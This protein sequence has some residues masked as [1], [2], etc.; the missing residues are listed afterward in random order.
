[1]E[2][3]I[4]ALIDIVEEYRLSA[5]F[6][7]DYNVGT[8]TKFG[9]PGIVTTT[10]YP[11]F[12]V[13]P[14]SDNPD[15]ETVGLRGYDCRELVVRIGFVIDVSDYFDPNVEELAGLRRV[16]QVMSS[17]G[18][19]LRRKSMKTLLDLEGVRNLVVAQTEYRPQARADAYVMVGL[20]TLGIYKQYPHEV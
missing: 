2:Q 19:R 10:E 20:I 18:R 16:T 3:V 12:F 15:V 9:D 11:Y 13:E 1:M 8:N 4:D 14:V 5:Y 7:D 6:P 17:L